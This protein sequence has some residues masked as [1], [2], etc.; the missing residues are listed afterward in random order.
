[1]QV[2]EKKLNHIL[3][4]NTA[5]HIQNRLMKFNKDPRHLA[6]KIA[7]NY[8]YSLSISDTIPDIEFIKDNLDGGKF[9][10]ELFTNLIEGFKKYQKD[11]DELTAPM[12]VNWNTEQLLDLDIF[13]IKMAIL[14]LKILKITP[15]KVAVD[16][17]VELAKEFGSEKSGKFVNGV[18]AKV[19]ESN[20]LDS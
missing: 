20:K 3:L 16:E 5:E 14:E 11:L 1:M 8:I 13:L 19:I 6:R 9:D 12:L 17:A 15:I 10:E 4:A 7:L 18:L 2:V